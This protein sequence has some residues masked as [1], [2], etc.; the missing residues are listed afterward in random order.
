MIFLSGVWR[1]L[2]LVNYE[3]DPRVLDPYVPDGTTLDAFEGKFYLSLVAFLFD[4]TSVLGLPAIGHRKF[5][6]VNLR[7]Y[8]KPDKD[9]SIRAVT[10]IK[11]LVPF[12]IIPFVA[13]NLF[14]ENYAS[15]PMDHGQ[16][17]N[18]LWYSWGKKS[19][20]RVTAKVDSELSLPAKGSLSEF[21]TEHY[22]GYT[23]AKKSTIEYEVKH[24]TWESCEVKE[25]S[26]DVDFEASY[27]KEFSFLSSCSP[28][29]VLFAKG[30]SVT[31]SFPSHM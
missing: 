12:P 31:V 8:V 17:E 28:A 11:E 3:V 5:E 18:R 25:Y 15:V 23:K 6:E 1:D 9:P 16:D 30:S 22:W 26:V 10:F 19:T 27:G 7:F 29:N 20:N 2:V 4:K 13:N 14:N 24:P 21:I